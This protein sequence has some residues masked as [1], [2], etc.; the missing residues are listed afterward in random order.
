MHC[1]TA[2]CSACRPQSTCENFLSNQLQ[3]AIDFLYNLQRTKDVPN[4][5]SV[6]HVKVSLTVGGGGGV[7]MFMSLFERNYKV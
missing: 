3:S 4:C 6:K 1:S 5:E 7:G 2:P